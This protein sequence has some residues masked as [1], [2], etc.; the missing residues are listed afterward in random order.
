MK[1][2]VGPPSAPLAPAAGGTKPQLHPGTI[3]QV[4]LLTANPNRVGRFYADLLGLVEG[5]REPGVSVWERP[6]PA[7]H[8]PSTGATLR[9]RLVEDAQAR[10]RPPGTAGL[11]HTAFLLPNRAALAAAARR[12]LAWAQ[13]D[14]AVRLAGYSDHGVS[15][16]VYG[17]DP[18]GNGVE[19]TWDR[20]FADWPRCP[21]APAGED[22][23]I[24]TWP[25][26]LRDLLREEPPTAGTAPST[27]SHVHLSVSDLGLAEQLFV[28]ELGMRVVQ[29]SFPGALFFAYGDYHHH[30]GANTWAGNGV[31]PP[32][33][34]VGLL[35]FALCT[36]A[37]AEV[38][39]PVERLARP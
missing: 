2:S 25:L 18:D 9:L 28:G 15:E 36:P 39:V 4:E 13:T 27:F 3:R 7:E 20:P 38:G 24:F 5:S 21:D 29:R 16:A 22:L 19:L 34:T 14:P 35:S 6:E 8:S 31:P 17:C 26:D 12:L 11:F 33:G 10:P 37:G 30:V 32:P 23:A 1:D